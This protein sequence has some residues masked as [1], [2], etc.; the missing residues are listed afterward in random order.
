MTSSFGSGASL[1]GLFPIEVAHTIFYRGHWLK[2]CSRSC[3]LCKWE[4]FNRCTITGNAHPS[5]S[6]LRQLFGSEN[7]VHPEAAQS[8]F[9]SLITSSVV[10]RNNEILKRL[11]LDAKREY[12]KGSDAEHRVHIFMADTYEA[13][14]L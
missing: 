9:S 11:V 7:K 12:E 3:Y 6:R 1:N 13:I 10:A 8:C 5:I 2:V 4:I 14:D